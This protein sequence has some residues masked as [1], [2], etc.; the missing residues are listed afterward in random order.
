MGQLPVPRIQ[1]DVVSDQKFSGADDR[2]AGF[3]IEDRLSEIRFPGGV[4]EFF[5]KTLIFPGADR[6]QVPAL[7]LPGR[8]FI[9]IDG[10]S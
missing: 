8:L 2:G 7:G 3:R 6:G 5:R 4:L 1:V 9:K 10:N